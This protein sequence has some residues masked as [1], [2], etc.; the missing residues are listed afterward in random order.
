MKNI[1]FY[2]NAFAICIITL[3]FSN[4]AWSNENLRCIGDCSGVGNKSMGDNANP[5]DMVLVPGGSFLMG[6]DK[7]VNVDTK[8]MSKRQQLRYAVS[9]AAF[10]DEG[11][12]HN[13]I[14]DAFHID[15]FEVSNTKYSEFMRATDHPAPAYWDD[16]KRNKPNQPVSG[17]NYFDATAYCSWDNKRLPTEA[18]WEKTARGPEGFKYP[19]GNDLDDSKGNWGRKQEFT[20]IVN[21][22][23]KGVSPYGA[24]SMAGNVFEWVQDWYDPN[25]YKTAKQSVN[26]TGPSKGVFLSATGTYVDR[27]ATG[28]KRV[29][30]GGSWYAPAASITTTHR[31]WNDPMNNSYGVGLGFRCARTV[32]DN[33]MLQARTFYMDAL[34][35]MGA[36]KYPQA[37]ASIKKALSQDGSNA[38]YV[39][40][41][42]M[43]QKQIP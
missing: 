42:K 7:K 14:L 20:A 39:Q 26:P 9:K 12:A 15:K 34:I 31:F 11:P 18:E 32:D 37:L 38:E 1:N 33:G 17:V 5:D 6:I 41:K 28:K 40:I 3:F 8:K 2:K 27:Y 23:P 19:W 22:Y 35:N 30:R 36:E 24:Y 43:I 16:S 4:Q 10:H 25:Y 29:I 21:A 13:V